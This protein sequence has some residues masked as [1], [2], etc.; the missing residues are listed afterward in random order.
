MTSLLQRCLGVWLIA[1]S[2]GCVLTPGAAR[3][4]ANT[5]PPLAINSTLR[6]LNEEENQRLLV[7]LLASPEMR[8]AARA[9]AGEI[10]DGTM[11][12]MTEPERVERIE[13]ISA[14]Y[15]ATLTRTVTRS[16]AAGLRS[17]L[18]PALAE[19][20][21]VMVSSA[22]REAM[23]EG[24]QRDLER[25]ASGVS[26]ASAEAA[27]RG[28]AEGITRDL[29]PAMREALLNEQTAGAMRTAMRS[30]ARE[31]VLGSNEAMT[32]IQRQQDRGAQPSFLSRLSSISEDGVRIMRLVSVI[33]IVLV[34]LLGV[35][36]IRLVQRGRRVAAESE[37]NAA[38]AAMFAQAIRAAEG[39]PWSNELTELLKER[40]KNDNVAGVIDEVL[41]PRPPPGRRRSA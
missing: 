38:S 3:D 4:L 23:R 40:L 24:Y 41:K 11:S 31:A 20:T 22:M 16:M 17:D 36:V 39:K 27:S 35:W 15:V 28:M 14:R 6:A 8:E 9:L 30:L 33:A 37:R 7:R 5:T 25:V 32:Q 21:R 19:V 29:V 12:A 10:A 26:R 13:Q 34:L 1:A 2:V 18:A